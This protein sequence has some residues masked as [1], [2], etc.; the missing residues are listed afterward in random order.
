[1]QPTLERQIRTKLERRGVRYTRGR[2]LL[3]GALSDAD[4]PRSAAELLVDLDR[5][6]PLSSIYR[7]LAALE[8]AEVLT[9]HLG[10]K[11]VTRYELAEWL[12]G[13]HHHLVCT[14]CG[15]VDDVHLSAD[16]EQALDR[17]VSAIAT[18]GGYDPSSHT[19]D[20]EGRCGRCA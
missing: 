10:T 11:G 2:R 8:Q 20:I 13:H 3:V 7:S 15:A 4:G 12:S 6:V 16:A 17:L 18:K 9:R 19:L 14:T 5:K 1:M